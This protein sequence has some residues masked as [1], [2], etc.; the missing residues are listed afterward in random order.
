[1]GSGGVGAGGTKGATV[2]AAGG[3]AVT[4]VVEASGAPV[5]VTSWGT[6]AAVATWAAGGRGDDWANAVPMPARPTAETT[7]SIARNVLFV[8]RSAAGL[9][10]PLSRWSR[11]ANGTEEPNPASRGAGTRA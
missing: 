3:A 11:W 1:M 8:G 9:C 10:I 5:V 7:T 4:V 6:G 2:T